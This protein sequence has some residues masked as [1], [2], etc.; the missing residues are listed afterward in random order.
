M[1]FR[2]NEAKTKGQETEFRS[3]KSEDETGAKP[4]ASAFAEAS[5]FAKASAG[6]VGATRGSEYR[7]AREVVKLHQYPPG[8]AH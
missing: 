4:G 7:A 1:V 5:S 2:T 6:Q 8:C 3:Q